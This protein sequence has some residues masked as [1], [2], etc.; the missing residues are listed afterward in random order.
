L[1]GGCSLGGL[2][3]VDEWVGGTVRDISL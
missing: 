2:G 1:I 3:W